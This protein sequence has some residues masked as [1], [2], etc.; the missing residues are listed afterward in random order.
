MALAPWIPH[1]LYDIYFPGVSTFSYVVNVITDWGISLFHTIARNVWDELVRE[2]REQI[3]Q[4]TRDVALRG[5]QTFADT[6][7]RLIERARW[8][9]TNSPIHHAYWYLEDYYKRLPQINPPQARQLFRRIG[10]RPPDR[11]NLEELE[12][13]SREESG[14]IVEKYEPP[15]G[16]FQRVTPDWMLPLILGLYGDITPTWSTY[17]EQIEAEEDGPKKKRRRQ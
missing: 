15:G 10:Q 7:A 14:Q 2:G 3:E 16:A 17:I 4:V 9:I 6:M 5:V 13:E 8:T 1:D 11:S 12:K